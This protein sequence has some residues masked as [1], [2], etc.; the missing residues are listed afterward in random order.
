MKLSNE[1]QQQALEIYK[2][3]ESIRHPHNIG[4]LVRR[5]HPLNQ[6][7]NHAVKHRR[8]A[9]RVAHTYN[10]QENRTPQE[11]EFLL[12]MCFH[13]EGLFGNQHMLDNPGQINLIID[14][15]ANVLITP[16]HEDFTSNLN[17]CKR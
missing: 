14:S 7:P 12:A 6:D 16:F 1:L 3:L 2:I 17:Q 11:N 13:V 10:S 5:K 15:G 4:N 8:E 9:P